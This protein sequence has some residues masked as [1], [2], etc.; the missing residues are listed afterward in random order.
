MHGA[1]WMAVGDAS[2]FIDPLFSTGVHLAMKS[3]SFAAQAIDAADRADG[4][5][6]LTKRDAASLAALEA[7]FAAHEAHVRSGAELFVTAVRAFYEGRLLPYLFTANPRVFLRRTITSMLAGDVFEDGARW[8]H[9]MKT[10]LGT[11]NMPATATA[12]AANEATA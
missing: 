8:K 4:G 7:R 6:E 3:A 2:G 12:T 1:G 5:S 11:L 9:D 10:R